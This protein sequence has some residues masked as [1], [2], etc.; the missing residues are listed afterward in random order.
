M[1]HVL[2]AAVCIVAVAFI[3]DCVSYIYPRTPVVIENTNVGSVMPQGPE[4]DRY[5]KLYKYHG[6]PWFVDPDGYFYRKNKRGKVEKCK[7][8]IDIPKKEK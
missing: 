8:Y 3:D 7:F 6:Y 4:R 2:A 5:M 1:K